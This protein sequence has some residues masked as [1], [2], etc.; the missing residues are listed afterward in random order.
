MEIENLATLPVTI[1][2]SLGCGYVSYI[3]TT[4]GIRNRERPLDQL[5][6]VLAYS[7]FATVFL[8][9][10]SVHGA[11]VASITALIAS[12]LLAII[13]RKFLSK[14]IVLF[15]RNIGMTWSNDDTSALM[16]LCRNTTHPVSQI[17]IETA[18]GDMLECRDT[19]VFQNSPFGPLM[20]GPDGDAAIYVTHETSL[21]SKTVEVNS[22]FNDE[23]GTQITYIPKEQIKSIVL[24]HRHQ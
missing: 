8:T 21:D 3:V 12:F 2:V 22:T 16:T 7:G 4:Y 20:I 23:Y 11:F 1:Q 6:I 13:W 17:A 14:K 9:Y 5:F 18:S 15:L 19:K 24:R 10:L